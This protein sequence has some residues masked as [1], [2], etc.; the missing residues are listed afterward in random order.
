MEEI[1][2]YG[3]VYNY[4]NIELAFNKARK[5]KT[6]KQ[7]VIKFEENLEEN[8]KLLQYELITQTY[9][10]LPLVTFI[11]RDPKTRKISKSDFR[12][13]IVHH[14]ICNVIEQMFDKTFIY[15]NY[16]NR[17]GKGAF[18][19]IER[20][21]QFKRKVSKNNTIICY[22]LKADI[23]HYFETV[24]HE[25]LM[26][27]LEKKINDARVLKLIRNIL[28]NYN[29]KEP[30]KG[31]PL[32]NLT[33]QFFAN[34]FLNELDQYVK[35]KLKVK[36]YIRYVDDFV[37]L[38]TSKEKL[39]E[40]KENIDGFLRIKLKLSLH[41]DKSKII[42]LSEGAGFLGFRIFFYH[43][44]I[45][46]KNLRKFE[47]KFE[48]M[49]RLYKEGV[50]DREIV[51]DKFEGWLAYISHGNTYK[52]SKHLV[53]EF[54]RCFPIKKTVK[55]S[56]VKKQENLVAR[57]EYC[58]MEFSPNK[59][60]HLLRKGLTTNQ[61][62]EKRSIKE[63]TVWEH[64]AKLIEWNQLSLWRL[65]PTEIINKILSFINKPDARLKEIKAKIKDDS[66]TY[67]QIDC[68]LAWVK[69]K[70]K[71]RNICQLAR[72]YQKT[73]C[74]RKCYTNINQRKLCNLK[75]KVLC[76]GNPNLEMNR[77]EFEDFF[78]SYLQICKLSM[79]ERKNMYLGMS[80]H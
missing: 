35:H 72:W 3:Q 40:L 21:D 47:K 4:E 7:Y 44:L 42:R 10:P 25:L 53:R 54:N 60:L 31:M 32:G 50:I 23:K 33:S 2:L 43:K 62:A 24:D 59:T 1:S 65:L 71:K 67:N 38:H 9:K 61:I 52:Y 75:F 77:A 11:L 18:K 46:K 45:R 26:L 49:K 34:V 73:H 68:V 27:I 15:D 30:G 41:P 78:N 70:N 64:Y 63:N 57:T 80:L 48:E 58:Q 13:R 74:Y 37:I 39:A 66:I 51:M 56:H 22:V 55:I 19:A 36:H 17:I 6:L 20:F 8:L 14:V 76:S 69:F 16:A 79:N 5:G 28:S 12:D 29:T